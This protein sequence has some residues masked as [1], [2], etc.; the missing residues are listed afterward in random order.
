MFSRR[1]ELN[2]MKYNQVV[3]E[4]TVNDLKERLAREFGQ[5]IRGRCWTQSQAAKFLKVSQ[6]RISNLLTGRY[7][8]FTLDTLV[9]LL[10]CLDRP[11]ELAFPD[12]DGWSRSQSS[13][14]AF[15]Q[16]E[17]HEKIAHYSQLILQDPAN[18]LAYSRRGLAYY[19]IGQFE[20]AIADYTRAFELDSSL[21]GTLANRSLA[22]HAAKQYKAALLDC[23]TILKK[24]PD[25]NVY[26]N[27]SLIYLDLQDYTKALEDMNR[28]T[29]LSPE[30][31]GPWINRASLHRKLNQLTQARE[32]YRRVLEI[33]PTYTSARQALSELA[34]EIRQDS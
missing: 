11:V 33:D 12:P 28:A 29:E 3:A 2:R 20:L 25:Y 32:D 17:S 23:E 1:R 18:S 34:D 4:N 31:P 6:P 8:K 13:A 21:P 7:H 26:A 15:N 24:F 27:R 16:S 22:Y 9:Y 19:R 14:S 30:R 5:V 10:I